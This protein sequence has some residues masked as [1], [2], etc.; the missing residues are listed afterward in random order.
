MT[1]AEIPFEFF[2]SCQF[3]VIKFSSRSLAHFPLLPSPARLGYFQIHQCSGTPPPG[4]HSG[5]SLCLGTHPPT[6]P[7]LLPSTQ[8]HLQHS[9]TFSPNITFSIKFFPDTTPS[10]CSSSF[11]NSHHI[12]HAFY[13]FF[14]FMTFSPCWFSISWEQRLSIHLSVLRSQQRDWCRPRAPWTLVKWM[15]GW[16]NECIECIKPNLEMPSNSLV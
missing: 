12:L 3:L 16:I 14:D 8:Q 9:W 4:F 6:S 10:T 13:N 15:N 5:S 7:C 1:Q 11:L 2:S